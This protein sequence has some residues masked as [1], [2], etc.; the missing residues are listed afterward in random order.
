MKTFSTMSQPDLK[1][2]LEAFECLNDSLID[3][4]IRIHADY[5]VPLTREAVYED[6]MINCKMIRLTE[7]IAAIDQEIIEY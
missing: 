3:K 2:T 4:S 7:L 1:L 5:S 6:N